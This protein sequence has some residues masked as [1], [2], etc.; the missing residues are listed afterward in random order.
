MHC[1]QHNA[2]DYALSPTILLQATTRKTFSAAHKG[3]TEPPVSNGLL[4]I[5]P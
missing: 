2:S 5:L 3:F 1:H 4:N